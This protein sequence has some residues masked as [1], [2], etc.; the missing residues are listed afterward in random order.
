MSWN[1]GILDMVKEKLGIVSNENDCESNEIEIAFTE[2]SLGITVENIKNRP[3]ISKVISGSIG[4]LKGLLIGD[5][6]IR[7][8]NFNIADFN[9][10]SNVISSFPERPL[11]IR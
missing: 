5:I 3:T 8:S 10:F 11:V 9:D 1:F 6:I 2:S 7:V 4:H